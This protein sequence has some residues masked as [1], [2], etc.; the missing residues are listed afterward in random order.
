[1][2]VVHNLFAVHIALYKQFTLY[3]QARRCA[4][5]FLCFVSRKLEDEPGEDV[6]FCGNAAQV[7]YFV[8]EYG[9]SAAAEYVFIRAA[10]H[11]TATNCD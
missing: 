5:E 9:L 4:C 3:L 6:F 1:M 2:N 10:L 8:P 7:C 11:V